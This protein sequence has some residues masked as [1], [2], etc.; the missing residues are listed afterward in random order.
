MNSFSIPTVV[1]KG[2]ITSHYPKD[3]FGLSGQTSANVKYS[4]GMVFDR[5]VDLD[6]SNRYIDPELLVECVIATCT[7]LTTLELMCQNLTDHVSRVLAKI[8][9]SDKVLAMKVSVQI[10]EED[11]AQSEKIT[12]NFYKSFEYFSHLS[13]I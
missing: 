11:Y 8:N 3:K 1:I 12:K 4:I 5:D 7:D 6:A 9:L 13:L 2:I 10:P